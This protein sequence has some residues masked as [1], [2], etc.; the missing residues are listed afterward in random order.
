M[1]SPHLTGHRTPAWRVTL[2]G[3]DVSAKIRPRL[4]QLSLTECR[5]DEADQLEIQLDD[6]DGQLAIP[7]RG[8][9]VRLALG[10]QD[11]GLVDK[12]EF[13]VDEVEYSGPPDTVTIRARSADMRSALRTRNERSFHDKTIAEI[14]ATIAEDHGLTP[15]VGSFGPVK[16]AHIDQTN[17]SDAAFLARIGKRYDAVATIKDKRLLFL[18][19]AQ[20]QTASGKETPTITLQRG[21]GDRIRFHA[22]DR[23]S[24]TGVRAYWQ[25]KAK[26]Q[27]RSVLYGVSGNAKRLKTLFGNEADA[28]ANAKA[29]WER[30]QRGVATFEMDLAFGRP[31]LIP[32]SR[33]VVT[34]L[35]NP[36]GT[37]TWLIARLA[38]SLND[39]GLTTRLEA[40]TAEA[41]EMRDQGDAGRAPVSETD[42]AD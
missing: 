7:A 16:V 32:Q 34:N 30:I 26:A 5:S 38:H 31:D 15:V 36:L 20:G 11:T 18:P 14:V 3:R 28:L 29:E 9:V 27:R 41:A 10:W 13:T 2:D 40:E 23:N 24:Y 22:A 37:Y 8:V 12:G 39:N 35:K 4:M 42:D 25:D 6:S 21:D 1:P 19:V 17:E 33:L